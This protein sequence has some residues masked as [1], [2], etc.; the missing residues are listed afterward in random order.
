MGRKNRLDV[1]QLVG[2]HVPGVP[3]DKPAASH[4]RSQNKTSQMSL[5]VCVSAVMAYAFLSS[6]GARGPLATI[7]GAVIE[8]DLQRIQV[9]YENVQ[10][11]G[12]HDAV[13]QTREFGIGQDY[14]SQHSVT[15]LHGPSSDLV[16]A[17]DI[18]DVMM[19]V[20]EKAGQQN[21]WTS[22]SNKAHK[23][24]RYAV[25]CMEHIEYVDGRA[26]STQEV[27]GVTNESSSLGWHD[28]GATQATVAL[29]LSNR[30]D[31]EGGEVEVLYQDGSVVRLSDL[32]RGDAAV[33]RGWVRHR[34]L[35]VRRG[36]RKVLVAEFWQRRRGDGDG[37]GTVGRPLDTPDRYR[38]SLALDPAAANLHAGWA[39]LSAKSDM[40]EDAKAGFRQALTLDPTQAAFHTGMGAV[41]LK[42]DR[43]A[44]ATQYLK[45]LGGAVLGSAS[46]VTGTLEERRRLEEAQ[47]HLLTAVSL[48]PLAAEAHYNIH[49]AH[50]KLG[51]KDEASAWQQAALDI[52][53]HLMTRKG[54]TSTRLHS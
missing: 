28:D 4:A 22:I 2:E 29:L 44:S 45:G 33:W 37:L 1:G 10:V 31:Y 8:A 7:R 48:D 12:D 42:T 3:K 41:L 26:S 17:R 20:A 40:I 32:Q 5:G 36:T 27:T 53:P 19:S 50:T 43:L 23:A 39:T 49:L 6:S 14:L 9:L 54:S 18:V 25:R 11:H 16:A 24:R 21:G 35:P 13:N 34:V 46:A 52:D 30:E 38:D 15:F 47:G 51:R